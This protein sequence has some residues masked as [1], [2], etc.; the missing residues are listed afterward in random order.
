MAEARRGEVWQ[1]DLGIAGKVRPCLLLTNY[2]ADDELALITIL[3]H[4]TAIRG[5]R[6]EV[7]IPKTFL[8]PGVFHLQQI[9]SVTVSRLQKYLGRLTPAEWGLVAGRLKEHLCLP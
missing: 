8:K 2:P 9:Q 5:N 1:I 6:C 7:N 4:T 3:P